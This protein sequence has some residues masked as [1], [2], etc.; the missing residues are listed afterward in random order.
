MDNQQVKELC[1]S[2]VK[3]ETENEVIELLQNLDLWDN[4]RAWRLYGDKENNYSTIGAQQG[5]PETAMVEKLINSV[6]SVLTAKCYINGT[7]PESKEA[8]RSIRDAVK[9]F[10]GINQGMLTNITPKE[11]TKLAENIGLVATGKRPKQGNACY[12]VFDLGEGQT[13]EKMPKTFLSIGEKNKIKIPFVQGKFNMGSTGVLRFCG[14]RN[15]QL[16]LTRRNPNLVTS[17]SEEDVKWGFTIVKRVYPDGEYK[18]S[19]YVYLV[20]P[21]NTDPA[22][23][24]V[25]RFKSETLPILPSEYPDP[26]G[27]PMA[28]GSY[29]KMYEYQMTGLKTNLTLDPYNR[30]SLLM[31]SLA[32]PIR[33]YERRNG[34]NANSAETTLNGLAVRLEEDKRSNLESESWPTAHPIS[35]AGEKMNVKVYAFKKDFESGKK[36]TDKYVKS[37]GVIFTINGQ[38]HGFLDKRFFHRKNI[39]LGNLSDSLIVTVDC[40]EVSGETREDLFMNSRDRLV[41]SS[42]LRAEIESE[43][44]KILKNHTGLSELKHARHKQEIENKLDD[45]KPL[46]DVVE[47]IM[48]QSPS[49]SS[50]FLK[51][52]K[53]KNPFN[54]SEKKAI[55]E[56]SGKRFPTYFTIEKKSSP[57]KPKHC[58]INQKSFRVQFDTDVVN[59]YFDRESDKG[60]HTL[61]L[62]GQ[63]YSGTKSMNPWNGTVTLNVELTDSVKEGDMLHFT[64]LVSDVQHVQP[65]KNEFYVLIGAEQKNNGGGGGNRRKSRS[66]DKGKGAKDT[67]GLAL[68]EIIEVERNDS[69]WNSKGFDDY[70]ALIV[71]YNGEDLGWAFYINIAN[72]HL[73]QEQKSQSKIDPK[74]LAAQYKYSLVIMGMSLI[75]AADDGEISSNDDFDVSDLVKLFTRGISPVVL[76]LLSSIGVLAEEE[77][78]GVLI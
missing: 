31:P 58:P 28:F 56:F 67:E 6:D 38:T 43:L 33:L 57:E 76:P 45:S 61:L 77:Q 69:N 59:D 63:P 68:P 22:Q 46:I 16:I 66:N 25:F 32:L 9:S 30:L 1:L 78:E 39:G 2:L 53:I 8:P 4:E 5:R 21:E 17:N 75:Q 10:F 62:N 20:N 12:S 34:F 42:E 37:E 41:E 52:F 11:R 54:L 15:L 13:P 18:S 51:G 70:S 44:T 71:Q 14:K 26:Y 47:K 24:G 23:N 64:S 65:F 73:L 72:K 48:K 27:K 29:V 36:P 3:T 19:R 74:I 55:D 49:L 50:L 60:V 40:S 35:V 7:N